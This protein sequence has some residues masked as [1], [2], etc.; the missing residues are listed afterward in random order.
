MSRSCVFMKRGLDDSRPKQWNL[1]YQSCRSHLQDG[2]ECSDNRKGDN[3]TSNISWR[4]R[5][6]ILAYLA[7]VTETPLSPKMGQS[8]PIQWRGRILLPRAQPRVRRT[9]VRV[10]SPEEFLRAREKIVFFLSC[11]GLCRNYAC[12]LRI[13]QASPSCRQRSQ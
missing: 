6:L 11:F 10:P 8:C 4:V 12:F 5:A 1:L 9:T 13:G 2:S 3:E 7:G